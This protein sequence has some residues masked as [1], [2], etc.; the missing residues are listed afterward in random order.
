M[1]YFDNIDINLFSLGDLGTFSNRDIAE[2][3]TELN[4]SLTI[5]GSSE[6]S[7]SVID[8]DFRMAKANYFQIRRDAF[9]KGLLFEI[10]VVETSRSEGIH[11][12]HQLDCRSKAIQLMKRDKRPEAFNGISGYDLA[13]RMA[14]RYNMNFV[15]QKDAKK[16]A[17]VKSNSGTTDDSVW[18]VL[19]TAAGDQEFVCFVSDNTL[20]Y[21][22]EK[23]LLGKWGDPNFA[24]GDLKFIP[25][26]W[27]EPT[28]DFLPGA[29]NKY[30][31]LDMP[32]VRR[33]DDDVRAAS[34]SMT[35]DRA[36]GVLLRPGMT[37]F[38]GGMHG[39]DGFYLISDVQFGEGTFEPVKVQFRTPVDPNKENIS[40]DGTKKD[41]T[42]SGGNGDENGI[43]VPDTEEENKFATDFSKVKAT[44]SKKYTEDYFA[45]TR[46]TGSNGNLI[47]DAVMKAAKYLVEGG[48]NKNAGPIIKTFSAKLSPSD[49]ALAESILWGF[50]FN[51]PV[52]TYAV[53]G[54]ISPDALVAI[55]EGYIATTVTS[56][57]TVTPAKGPTDSSGASGGTILLG[58][59]QIYPSAVNTLIDSY[60]DGQW[61]QNSPGV[62]KETLKAKAKTLASTIYGLPTKS[63]KMTKYNEIKKSYSGGINSFIYKA[64]RQESVVKLLIS[65]YDSTR[66]FG[67][68]YPGLIKE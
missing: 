4:I 23:W 9:Y 67:Q 7:V 19:Q 5:S 43:G 39:F 35:V 65:P 24:Y 40:T 62:T 15:G 53:A 41:T 46:Y 3:I 30:V 38:L 68:N 34:G 50:M 14:L 8:P 17:T 55:K 18:S 16:Q 28:V 44:D 12:K 6:I 20:F 21:A 32:T 54:G 52:K 42:K 25:F 22:S 57:T 11:P 2:A 45:H 66:P 27:P 64:V 48:D 63:A 60:I 1:A 33:S 58:P 56:T 13:Q 61:I 36:N 47:Q 26:I 59:P 51:I 29:L 37:I 49:E 31:L 10:A